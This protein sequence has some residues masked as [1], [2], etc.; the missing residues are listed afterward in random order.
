MAKGLFVKLRLDREKIIGSINQFFESKGVDATVSSDWKDTGN[1]KRCE[2][3]LDGEYAYL[4]VW[5]NKDGTTT[6]G[7]KAGVWPSKH[8]LLKSELCQYI[9]DSCQNTPLPQDPWFIA[10][11]LSTE[12]VA[13]IVSL[14][15][16]SDFLLKKGEPKEGNGYPTWKF[17]GV[18]NE[19]L[20]L[21]Y[22]NKGDKAKA[23]LMIQGKVELLFL[24]AIEVI[25]NLFSSQ[26]ISTRL[27]ESGFFESKIEDSVVQSK[28][29]EL[30]PHSFDKLPNDSLKNSILQAVVFLNYQ[31]NF[32][33]FTCY[34]FNAFRALEGH[35][36]HVLSELGIDF[37]SKL[38]KE[39]KPM[40]TSFYMFEPDGRGY[41]IQASYL[42]DIESKYIGK[43]ILLSSYLGQVYESLSDKRNKYFHW[44]KFEVGVSY[45][46]T[47][48][49]GTEE[50]ARALIIECLT[51]IDEYY[52]IIK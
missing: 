33:D 47:L 9:K 4:D 1:Q 25:T 42:S 51:K 35:L 6:I 11:N 27:N 37:A 40:P 21:T 15:E 36:R 10:E 30:M 26:E 13:T 5:Y 17:I 45:D 41:K 28:V 44:E 29:R 19:S 12:E 32:Y 46:D 8:S 20:T 39:G 43:S 16:K 52:K 22:F 14:I 38:D 49:V 48:I 7:E 50:Q 2:I 3:F 34:T 23:K 18:R 24:E 31:S